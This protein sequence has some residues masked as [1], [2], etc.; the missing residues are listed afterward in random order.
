VLAIDQLL[1]A[2]W[3]TDAT[4]PHSQPFLAGGGG[5]ALSVVEQMARRGERYAI[6]TRDAGAPSVVAVAELLSDEDLAKA[7]L[8][9]AVQQQ[10]LTLQYFRAL[11]AVR[12][13]AQLTHALRSTD[14][15]AP[16]N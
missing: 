1:S 3:I 13:G 9:P 2:C 14:T 12:P 11:A 6:D 8:P 15:H 7:A 4:A 5:I 10:V 16:L